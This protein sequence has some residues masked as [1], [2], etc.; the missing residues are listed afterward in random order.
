MHLCLVF[1]RLLLLCILLA[2][3][4][5]V[6]GQDSNITYN[7][8][9]AD[10]QLFQRDVRTNKAIT[11]I[12]GVV[13]TTSGYT[14]LEARL[15]NESGNEVFTTR[16][17]LLY[18]G[19]RAP[20]SLTIEIPAACNNHRL[21]IRGFKQ[22][23]GLWV[24]ERR[25]EKLLAGDI[26]LITGQSNAIA[27]SS[28]N[29]ADLDEYTRS[30]HPPYGWGQLNFSFPGQWGARLAKRIATDVRIPVAIFNEAAGANS[31]PLYLKDS[32]DSMQGNYGAMYKRLAGAGL[33]RRARAAFWFHGEADAWGMTTSS[34]VNYFRQLRDAWRL[35][36]G[37]ERVFLFQMRYQSCFSPMPFI[38]E[39]HRQI[40]DLEGVDVMSTTNTRHD[41]CHFYYEDG[42]K[43]LGDRL[44]DLVA[45]NFYNRN[46]VE[47][48]PP[49]VVRA[50]HSAPQEITIEVENTATL[51]VIG[52]PWNDF[53]TEGANVPIV[54]GRVE[55]NLIRLTTNAAISN[56]VTGISYLGHT[57]SANRWI[58]NGR[59]VGLLTFHNVPLARVNTTEHLPAGTLQLWPNPAP[60]HCLVHADALAGESATIH[61][62]DAIGRV[63]WHQSYTALPAQPL[64][65]QTSSWPHG[66]YVVR[67]Q[68]VRGIATH[69][70]VVP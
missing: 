55:G 66:H 27:W 47:A 3:G 45:Y 43:T 49:D 69:H 57:G 64:W 67:L 35:D 24:S 23:T 59:D 44:F 15:T 22:S 25:V 14:Q 9:P 5:Q 52:S 28:P 58:V 62:A 8:I 50:Y 7:A 63:V 68:T 61:I 32:K 56:A 26:F 36:Y 33:P 1:L 12:T 18:T 11:G 54:N 20:F 42:Y 34:Y 41:S 39:A 46:N 70:L 30:W 2:H 19:S 51:R 10:M 13:L 40:G 48:L 29:F 17:N 6:V 16:Q 60:T 31:I 65:I 4:L 38:M 53:R 37:V 21:E